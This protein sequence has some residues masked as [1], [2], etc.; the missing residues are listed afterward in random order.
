MQ[1]FKIII[2]NS[3]SI[4]ISSNLRS[5]IR[6]CICIRKNIK[7]ENSHLFIFD[8]IWR[9]I[10][11]GLLSDFGATLKNHKKAKLDW[12]QLKLSTQ[13]KNMYMY[14]NYIP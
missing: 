5:N 13:H 3:I 1:G 6:T 11:R 14:Q 10:V 8:E 7:V 12:N 4:G 2:K 9:T